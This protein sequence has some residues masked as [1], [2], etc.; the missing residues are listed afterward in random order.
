MSCGSVPT[1]EKRQQASRPR[2]GLDFGSLRGWVCAG[3]LESDSRG[4]MRPLDT[5]FTGCRC[6]TPHQDVLHRTNK[7]TSQRSAPD[8]NVTTT[9][10]QKRARITSICSGRRTQPDSHDHCN[11]A[12]SQ[13]TND[14]RTMH[15]G[16]L[17]SGNREGG[18]GAQ[19]PPRSADRG[20][21]VPGIRTCTT[22]ANSSS[23]RP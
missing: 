4:R 5:D 22:D 8:R 21:R 18:K 3:A 10:Y 9:P 17:A 16:F 20:W 6:D 2:R 23:R 15:G 13:R 19:R 1:S 11:A 12:R 14:T 7:H